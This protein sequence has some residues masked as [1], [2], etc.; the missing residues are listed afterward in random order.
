MGN[1]ALDNE[2][3]WAFEAGYL[4]RFLDGK[5]TVNLELYC[6]VHTDIINLETHIVPDETTGLPDLDTSSLLFLNS[7]EG[8][9]ILGSELT[10][11]FKLTPEIILVA[12]W[13]HREV[14]DLD[15]GEPWDTVPKN[16]M[17]VGGRFHAGYGLVG[18]LYL[19][20][21]SE[22]KDRWVENPGGLLEPSLVQH[23]PNVFLVL[24]RLG[25]KFRTAAGVHVEA[26]LKLFLPVS[27]SR[28]PLFRI[29]EKGGVINRLGHN[30]GGEELVRVLTAYLQG[31][32]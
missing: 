9:Y 20:S 5:L 24:G 2:E 26:G 7:D 12:T 21:R 3:L 15:S 29:R 25:W 30:Y 32:F 19:H 31:S 13:A 4:G 22:F 16:L 28:E 8:I 6:N 14:F 1:P 10:T 11:R 18:S 23:M 17:A 27:P